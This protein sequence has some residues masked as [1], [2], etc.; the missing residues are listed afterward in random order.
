MKIDP[1]SLLIGTVVSVIVFFGIGAASNEG[2][3]YELNAVA[4]NSVFRTESVSGTELHWNGIA[5]KD[6]TP[7]R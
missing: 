3:R 5:W 6:I 1:K 4:H 7:P 2:R